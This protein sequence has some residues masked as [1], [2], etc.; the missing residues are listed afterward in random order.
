LAWRFLTFRVLCRNKAFRGFTKPA[1][2]SA[3]L[4]RKLLFSNFHDAC[5]PCVNIFPY[6]CR[7]LLCSCST[8]LPPVPSDWTIFG[9][10]P[11]PNILVSFVRLNA[12]T[13]FTTE[14][15]DIQLRTEPIVGLHVVMV[16][17]FYV[18]RHRSL[19]GLSSPDAPFAHPAPEKRF[20]SLSVLRLDMPTVWLRVFSQRKFKAL[21][22]YGA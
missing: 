13:D 8:V 5:V 7:K 11:P 4:S 10:V 16:G 3:V 15:T 22:C 14:L 1:L 21:V 2:P 6:E 17:F 18:R 12:S 20:F 19:L 9:L